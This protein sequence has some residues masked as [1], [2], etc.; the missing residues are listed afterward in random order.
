MAKKKAT[1]IGKVKVVCER[2][3]CSDE[4]LSGRGGRRCQKRRAALPCVPLPHWRRPPQNVSGVARAELC[5][6]A[7]TCRLA[8]VGVT[9]SCCCSLLAPPVGFLRVREP[10]TPLR[11]LLG[12]A[13][14]S[15]QVLAFLSGNI[16]FTY[17]YSKVACILPYND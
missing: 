2:N 11:G 16:S 8:A 17:L 15:C 3:I 14:A 12:L 9:A 5:S 10:R 1:I 13:H 4:R 6:S 7:H